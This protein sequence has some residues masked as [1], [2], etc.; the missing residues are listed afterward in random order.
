MCLNYISM[1]RY[2][3]NALTGTQ[4]FSSNDES[5]TIVGNMLAIKLGWLMLTY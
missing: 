4:S 5:A 2:L 3:G 1:S